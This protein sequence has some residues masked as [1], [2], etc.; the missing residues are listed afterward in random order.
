MFKDEVKE[1]SSD[2]DDA[3]DEHDDGDRS[4]KIVFE[5]WSQYYRKAVITYVSGFIEKAITYSQD[6][7]DGYAIAHSA[8]NKSMK[9]EAPNSRVLV[10]GLL[11]ET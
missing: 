2:E 10:D 6:L 8:D 1:S 11:D 7:T 9:L 3:E 4:A 5:G